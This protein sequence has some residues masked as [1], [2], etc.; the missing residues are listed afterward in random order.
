MKKPAKIFSELEKIAPLIPVP[1]SWLDIN[2]VL[3]GGNDILFQVIGATMIRTR[4]IGKTL[5]EFYP[6]D[7]ADELMKHTNQVIREKK[8]ITFEESIED[9]ETGKTRWFLTTR[10]P[11]FDDDGEEVIGVNAT[12]IEITDRKE[13]EQLREE[14]HNT[15]LEQAEKLRQI[16]SAVSHDIYSPLLS[17]KYVI[18]LL[19]DAREDARN[20]INSSIN[21]INEIVSN[22]KIKYDFAGEVVQESADL[23]A[24]ELITGLVES[25][26]CEKR[27]TYDKY[28]VNLE[29]NIA[30]DAQILF[31]N[32]NAAKF[33]RLVSNIINNAVEAIAKAGHSPGC[34]NVLLFKKHDTIYLQI[35]DNG[36][37][38]PRA[39]IEKLGTEKISTKKEDG[40]G[41]GLSTAIQY[42]KEWHGEYHIDSE[43]GVGV[44]FTVKLPIAK[45][46]DWFQEDLSLVPGN[47]VV[48]LDDDASI[49]DVWESRFSSLRDQIKLYH[50][51]NAALFLEKYPQL[52]PHKHALYLIDYELLGSD[53]TG[54]D[55]IQKLADHTGIFLVTS[56]YEDEK[57]RA[58]CIKLGVKIIPKYFAAYIPIHMTED[59]SVFL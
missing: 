2:G 27:V 35:K 58:E 5:H 43:E 26:Y 50:F 28:S 52:K 41:I 59:M 23:I 30:D 34:I 54:N 46:P 44:T 9:I 29:L 47:L 22:L 7:V 49:H 24:P 11:L 18:P 12:S 6:K 3:L 31:A 45:T 20:I 48:I 14:A 38:F 36:C 15:R 13:N 37:G 40:H 4:I 10:A 57:I 42:L 56:H 25:V 21:R 32:I 17:L 8:L 39:N 55:V 1:M 19:K 16:A 53:V 51:N 33:K